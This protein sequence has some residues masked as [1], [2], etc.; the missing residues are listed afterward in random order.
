[1]GEFRAYRPMCYLKFDEFIS[2]RNKTLLDNPSVVWADRVKVSLM[3]DSVSDF[4]ADSLLNF[5]T[6]DDELKMLLG[7]KLP[8]YLY[9]AA[10]SGKLTAYS[11]DEMKR[12]MTIEEVKKAGSKTDT[13]YMQD[14]ETSKETMEIVRKEFDKST[15]TVI[16]PVVEWYFDKT[17]SRLEA[18]VK[19]AALYSSYTSDS[20]EMKLQ[21]LF[22]VAF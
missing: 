12:K 10:C 5:T 22:R 3:A 7:R 8:Q 20:G 18:R 2:T 17:K 11:D 16:K 1:M 15:L 14:F 13:V 21:K 9:D 6:Q 19:S 4:A